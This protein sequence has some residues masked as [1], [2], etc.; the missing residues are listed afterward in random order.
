M[1]LAV[2]DF[3]STLMDGETID[4]LADEFGIGNEVKKITEEAMSGRLDFFESLIQRVALLKGMDYKKVVDICANLPL[5]TGSKEIVKEL[6]KMNYKVVC[7]SGGFRLGT[8]PAKDK[9]GLDADFSNILHQ[10]DGVLTGLVGGDMMF[11]YSKG[12]MIQRLQGLLKISKED[13]LV[14]GDGANDL[15]MFEKADTRVAF[16]AKDILKKEANII[17]DTK[18]LTK[19]LDY[20]KA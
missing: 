20:I 17:V 6:Q 15:S 11:G 10:K 8:S 3:D 14:C 7:F 1:K 13:T 18:D 16:C 9:L 12:D 5:M 19:I 4:F 2:F